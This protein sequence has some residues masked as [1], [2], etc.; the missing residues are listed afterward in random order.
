MRYASRKIVV[1]APTWLGDAVMSLQLIGRL[2]ESDVRVSVLADGYASRVYLGVDG[3]D[4]LLV[5]P[6]SIRSRSRAL[7]ASGFNGALLLPPS[8]SSALGVFLG[9]VRHRV[10]YAVDGRRWLLSEAVRAGGLRGEHLTENYARLGSRLMRRLGGILLEG[11]APRVTVF[12]PERE[13]VR[14][15]LAEHGI[16][17]DYAVVVPGATYGPTKSWP[18]EK[19]QQ[20]TA[21]LSGDL[22]VVLAGGVAERQLCDEVIGHSS[23]AVNLAGR[24]SLGELFALVEGARVVVANDSG[25]PHVAAS[26]GTPAVVIFGST[27]P[28]WT[29]P[30]GENVKVICEPVHCSP[31]FRREC[32]THLE[33]YEGIVPERVLDAAR[34]ACLQKVAH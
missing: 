11:E 17:K 4:E 24:T 22:P 29:K 7:R 26:L 32:P 25:V 15:L 33:C 23:T 18:S 30:V 2:A 27:S 19:Y 13:S 1:I 3:V 16:R 34:E 14:R 10:G 6:K 12:D 5:L 28:T 9:G 31:C 21:D 8:F 20:V